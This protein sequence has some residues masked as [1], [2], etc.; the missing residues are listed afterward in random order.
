MS[1]TSKKFRTERE[2]ER[3]QEMFYDMIKH[4]NSSNRCMNVDSGECMYVPTGYLE[5]RSEGCAIGRL[6]PEWA[7]KVV[8]KDMELNIDCG[9]VD[10]LDRL[11]K[12]PKVFEDISTTFL[13]ELQ[14]IHDKEAF[15]NETGLSYKGKRQ[16]VSVR[17]DWDLK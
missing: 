15:W 1:K 17:E 6:L 14:M 5:E 9:V 8:K 13:M 3:M 4:Y 16:A 2:T 12:M 10:L 7:K 11:S